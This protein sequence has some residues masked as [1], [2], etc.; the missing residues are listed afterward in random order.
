M[1]IIIVYCMVDFVVYVVKSN[2][3]IL[4]RVEDIKL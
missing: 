4:L 1:V 3:Y 2:D